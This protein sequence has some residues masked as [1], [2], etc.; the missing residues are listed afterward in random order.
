MNIDKFLFWIE[1]NGFTKPEYVHPTRWR[2]MVAWYN[3]NFGE[4]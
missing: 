1:Y 4:V 3:R 2:G